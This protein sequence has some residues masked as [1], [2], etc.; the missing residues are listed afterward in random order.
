V[1]AQLKSTQDTLAQL[2][3][4]SST[5]IEARRARATPQRA[6]ARA[7]DAPLLPGAARGG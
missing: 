3:A 5:T 6:R 7:A 2:Q 4:D 1:Q